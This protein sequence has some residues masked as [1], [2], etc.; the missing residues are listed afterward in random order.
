MGQLV[1][2]RGAKIAA[3]LHGCLL[4]NNQRKVSC[5]EDGFAR[6]LLKISTAGGHRFSRSLSKS[7]AES[8]VDWAIKLV[9]ATTARQQKTT[10]NSKTS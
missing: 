7:I 5:W 2:V 8:F 9:P 1:F 4:G 3:S 10:A 6:N